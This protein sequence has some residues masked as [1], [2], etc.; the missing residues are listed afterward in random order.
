MTVAE[1]LHLRST[2]RIAIRYLSSSTDRREGFF[3]TSL[4]FI[5]LSTNVV[6]LVRFTDVLMTSP[7]VIFSFQNVL[8]LRAS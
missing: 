3:V 8:K 6:K 5:L 1:Q 7:E 4:E 2:L